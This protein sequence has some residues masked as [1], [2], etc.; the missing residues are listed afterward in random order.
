MASNRAATPQNPLAMVKR[1]ARWKLRIMEKCVRGGDAMAT[2]VPGGRVLVKLAWKRE[3]VPPRAGT[4]SLSIE[5]ETLAQTGPYCRRN[6]SSSAWTGHAWP[7]SE[8]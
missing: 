1:S 4:P 6:D 8:V 7:T 2:I 3:G 5:R